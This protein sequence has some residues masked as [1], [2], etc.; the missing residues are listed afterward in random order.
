MK[1]G[2]CDIFC[3]VTI[4]RVR[5]HKFLE[6]NKAESLIFLLC[7]IINDIVITTS[8]KNKVEGLNTSFTADTYSKLNNLG[9]SFENIDIYLKSFKYA[10]KVCSLNIK[11]KGSAPPHIVKFMDNMFS[12]C[13]EVFKNPEN[14]KIEDP[15]ISEEILSDAIHSIQGAST[16]STGRV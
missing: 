1:S 5:P 12:F 10:A 11:R 8:G 16:S 3:L 4:P 15:I 14:F 7:A 13:K 2:Q 6:L 9:I